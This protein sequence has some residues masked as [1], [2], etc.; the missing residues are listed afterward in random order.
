[1]NNNVLEKEIQSILK[2]FDIDADF[3][4]DKNLI[5]LGLFLGECQRTPGTY[6]RAVF[7]QIIKYI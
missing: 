6:A 7:P 5:E 1:M 3:G 4:E 2:E